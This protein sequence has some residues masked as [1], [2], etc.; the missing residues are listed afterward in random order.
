MLQNMSI[1]EKQIFRNYFSFLEFTAYENWILFNREKEDTGEAE[2][3]S[4]S[5]LNLTEVASCESRNI[6][7][8]NVSL[9]DKVAAF[10]FPL[11]PFLFLFILFF[12]YFLS[13]RAFFLILVFSLFFI[14]RKNGVGNGKRERVLWPHRY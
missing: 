3:S 6:F 2:Q 13:Y 4:K 11:L 5:I 12:S 14:L 1:C 7:C 10:S 9:S 8:S